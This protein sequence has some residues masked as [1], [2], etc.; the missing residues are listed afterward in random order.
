MNHVNS[1]LFRKDR[2]WALALVGA[3]S[4]TF[5]VITALLLASPAY[6][7]VTAI[8]A[9]DEIGNVAASIVANSQPVSIIGWS[10]SGDENL[11]TVVVTVVDGGATENTDFA[12]LGTSSASGVA[13]YSDTGSSDG[14]FDSGDDLLLL[15]GVPSWAT[16]V[17][18][19]SVNAADPNGAV[20]AD[21]AGVNAGD[22]FFIV[23]K[24]SG[25]IGSG[26]AFTVGIASANDVDYDVTANS[27][28]T[29]TSP[30]VTADT[31][32]PTLD[33]RETA[34]IDSHTNNYFTPP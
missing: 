16:L 18:T 31:T 9:D 26:D 11:D 29:T 23:I 2:L 30:T 24:T 3:L 20:P 8:S 13:I 6:A 12:S 28:S 17:A 10:V 15:D 22:D 33:A 25:T 7:A 4:F 5:M 1:I 34:R 19:V 14:E 32:A 27:G 21:D